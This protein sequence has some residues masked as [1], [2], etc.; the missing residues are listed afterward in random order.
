M[1][2]SICCCFLLWAPALTLKNLNYSV[3]EEQ[4]AGTVIGNIG[5]DARLQ[6]GLPPAERGGSGGR[7]KSGS[8]RVLEN[9]APHLLDVDADSGL[10]YTKQRIDR[11]SLCRHN[12]KCQLSLE[13]F[14]NDKEICMI[15]V[16]IQDIN[17]N[18]PSFP[19]DQIEMDISENA[20]PGT[21]FPLTSAHDPDAGE[22]GLRTYLLTRDDHGLFALDVKSR[23]DGTKFPELVI[24][25]A[26]D[27]EQQN[28]HTLVLTALDG[29]EPP[30]S[31]T[32][33]I[34]VKVIDSNDNSPV[35]EAPSYLVELPENAP[36]GTVVID[37]NATDA[38]E[39]PN[40][41]VLYSFSSYV[42][43][44]VREL[45]SIDPK[46]GLIRVKGNLDYEENGM[47]EIDVQARDLGPNPIPAHCKVTVKLIDRN[48]NAPSIG[49]VSVRQGA[50]SEA[51]PPG[52]VIALVRVTDRDSG[53]NGQLQ[54]R[55]LGG[56]GTGGGGGLGGPGG[57]VPFKLE[58]NYDNFYTVVTDR[59]LDRETQDEYN[60]TIVA[61]DG[62]SP[63]LN[64]T[65]SF[66]V[67]ILDEN[68][69]PPRFTKGLY[70]LQVHE[71]NI[72]GEYLG[73]VLAQDP[74]LGQN[75]TVS[76]SIL[77]SHIG[78]VSIYTYVSVN[79][80]NGAIYALRSF[81][82]EQTKAF[83]FKVLAK[84]SGAPSHLESNA[85]VRVTVLDVNDNAPVI[86]LPTLQN[87]TA[88]LQV[89]RNAGL[90]YLVS[91]VR[92]LDSD[93][94]ESGRLTYEIVDGNDDHLFEIDPS[95]GE[96]RTL[97]P[98]WEDVTPVVELVVKVTDHGKPTLSAVAKLI[99]RSVSGSL[100]EGVPRVNGEQHHWD[101]SLPL[102]V[103]LST[104]SI[105][106][107]AAMI[108][109][110]VKCKRENKEI[111]TYNCRIAEYSHPQLGGGKGK[112]KKINKND[113]MLVQSE[114]EERNAMNVMNV[115]SSPSLAT[116]P[117]YFDYQTR[118]PL[119]SPRSEV[120]YLKPASN[121][122]TVP[123][124]HAGCH[125]SFTGQGT[126]ASETPATRMSIIQTDNFPAEPN[127]MGSRQQFVQSSTFKDP[128]R[129][130]LRDS[131][132]G[133]SDQAD[134]DQ[135]TN[136]GSCCD[137]SVREALKM[138]TTSTK[139]QPLEQA[140]PTLLSF[141][142]LTLHTITTRLQSVDLL[143]PEPEECVNCT[144]ECRVLGH[145]DRCW[146]PQFP[147]ANQAENA[148]YRT[149][150][151]VPTVEA[152][153]ETETY[154]TVNPT[155]K[156]TFCTFGKDKREHTILI[157]NVK[158]YL[159]AKRALSPLLQEVPSASSSPTKAC[160]EPCTS[161]KGSLDGCEAKP[162]ALA[163]ASSQ[164]LPTDSQYL[165][166][167]K[168]P[169]DPPFMASD[170]MARVFADVHSRA[171]R[172]SSEMGAV[173]EQLDHPNR[174]LGRESV[175]AEEVVR[176]IDKLLQDC[177]GNDPVAVRK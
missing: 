47:L 115:V 34:N 148:D 93:F 56:G 54:C 27:R 31:A 160:I 33:Q 58:E 85:T 51:A 147:A 126:N 162:G 117:M 173:L 30:R 98:F 163:E 101:M 134:S 4:G 25:K 175:D 141:A 100:P 62:G 20:A 153:V 38:D 114:V 45:F 164:Y 53:K 135:D 91:T 121:N 14:A 90:G 109:I 40:G 144:D 145:S 73:S 138:K 146:M 35:F 166:P 19:S 124:G 59:P 158:P 81:N 92:A 48:D 52:T 65:K 16:E 17:D 72:P 172:D 69:N 105:I 119:S 10:L 165:S 12:A 151:F 112:K 8:Y 122:L 36:L 6:P 32:V 5:K 3:P 50:L 137:M 150:L 76:Y 64:S 142:I 11:E 168:Q 57:S 116:S 139:S 63:P 155:G 127:Y 149:N 66:A 60:V 104:I 1:Y 77:P 55:V 174:D 28:H 133:D 84:D 67:K 86:V 136:K 80:T 108:T 23:G 9:S 125:T 97:H 82:Y 110:A 61:R 29:G 157:A 41:E 2:L 7:G 131:G 103:T 167:S 13:V 177:R 129:A 70:V 156:K 111:R 75:G 132:H 102:I 44:R 15:K 169:R 94:G 26:L 170:Q 152:N 89:P 140:F 39:G 118:L 79:P 37:L 68:D 107:L 24:Q 42:P 21:R 22:N 95:S 123:Q 78:D 71:N 159:K 74:D 43:D 128:E 143:P 46:T 161:T 83:E 171:S 106:L 18:A 120:M 154:E 113:I 99:I 49:F 130:S 96:I 176:E 88:E 87:D